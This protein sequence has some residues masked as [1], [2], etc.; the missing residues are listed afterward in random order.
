MELTQGEEG[1]KLDALTM[2]GKEL[3]REAVYSVFLLSDR[4]WIVSTALPAVGCESYD[5]EID[6]CSEF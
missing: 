3:D 2:D 4:D 6:P 5:A 1:Y